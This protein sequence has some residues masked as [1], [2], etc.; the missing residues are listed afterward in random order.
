MNNPFLEDLFNFILGGWKFLEEFL[1]SYIPS[2]INTLYTDAVNDW[3][4]YY[5]GVNVG[6]KPQF[7]GT[8][9]KGYCGTAGNSKMYGR[10]SRTKEIYKPNG[11]YETEGKFFMGVPV[12]GNKGTGSFE[13]SLF[14]NSLNTNYNSSN[15]YPN[16]I[17][18][19]GIAFSVQASSPYNCSYCRIYFNG[20][21]VAHTTI[22]NSAWYYFWMDVDFPSSTIELYVSTSSTKPTSPTL[23]YSFSGLTVVNNAFMCGICSAGSEYNNNYILVDYL[24]V[25]KKG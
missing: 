19:G 1:E 4:F 22:S 12:G 17:N 25:E 24:K 10:I 6:T 20:S 21:S 7:D 18:F 2:S 5:S 15:Y 13:I 23:S 14:G 11:R 3:N 16:P 9:F 8:Y